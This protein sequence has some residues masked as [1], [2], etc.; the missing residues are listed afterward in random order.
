MT[1]KPKSLPEGNQISQIIAAAR[2]DP[3]VFG[4]LYALYAQP[5]FRYMFSRIG[6]FPEAEDAT[7]QTFLAALECFPKYKHDG[8]FSS[9]LFAIA[10]NKA[11][12]YFRKKHAE[13]SLDDAKHSDADGNLLQQVIQTERIAA[14]SQLIGA[15]PEEE[16][17]MIRLRYV[18]ELSFAEIGRVF[19]QKEDT[20][21][22]SIYRL[23]ARLKVLLEEPHV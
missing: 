1:I 2:R 12:D 16:Q 14:L 17:E 23:L 22:K 9:W 8:Y 20:V 11:V 5:V 15:L 19:N 10:R 4:E 3:K 18:A 21:K 13:T 7:A 6:N